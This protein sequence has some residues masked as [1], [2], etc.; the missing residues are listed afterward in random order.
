MNHL[1]IVFSETLKTSKRQSR[2]SEK[3][4]SEEGFGKLAEVKQIGI[5]NNCFI[6]Q[7]WDENWD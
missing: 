1:W 7:R 4:H 3:R 5:N 6:T 2:G